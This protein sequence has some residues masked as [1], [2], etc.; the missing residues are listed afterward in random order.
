MRGLDEIQ[1]T[2]AVPHTNNAGRRPVGAGGDRADAIF[3]AIFGDIG[4]SHERSD[5]E[6]AN[7]F[8]AKLSGRP[9]Q[10]DEAGV[11]A[12]IGL[13]LLDMF[14]HK[15]V[16]ERASINEAL[17]A[18]KAGESRRKSKVV[19]TGPAESAPA[20]S[21]EPG[22]G[23]PTPFWPTP[24]Q[25]FWA[26]HPGLNYD[27]IKEAR[28]GGKTP[29]GAITFIGKEWDSIRAVPAKPVEYL[30]GV[31]PAYHGEYRAEACDGSLSWV[32]VVNQNADPIS[33][34]I[35]EAALTAARA[36]KNGEA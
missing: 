4:T 27:Q 11:Y 3:E 33:Y 29:I 10:R 7:D 26:E 6:V 8:L 30:G 12:L 31:R 22:T 18:I 19:T 20:N 2:N 28:A 13:V 24:F 1:K 14:A 25:K 16:P 36:R 15:G 9:A 17:D 23:R 32:K 35:P 5:D 21:G 34:Q